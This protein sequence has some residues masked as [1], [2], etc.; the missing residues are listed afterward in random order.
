M[1]WS[2]FPSVLLLVP[3][4]MGADVYRCGG[5]NAVRYQ[6]RPCQTDE[7]QVLWQGAVGFDASAALPVERPMSSAPAK[8]ARQPKPMQ[9]P[10]RAGSGALIGLAHDEA[11]CQ[12]VRRQREQALRQ[13]R[14]APDLLSER[15]WNDRVHDACR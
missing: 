6:D 14:R 15:A 12:R 5:G 10:R 9:R 1:K 3:L 2:A 4:L 7:Q 8:A 13:R 11:H